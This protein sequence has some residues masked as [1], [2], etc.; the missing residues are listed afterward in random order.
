LY[1]V[2][3]Y[4]LNGTV[5]NASL[6]YKA[7]NTSDRTQGPGTGFAPPDQP[8]CFFCLNMA[9]KLPFR[10]PILRHA[11]TGLPNDAIKTIPELIDFHARAN[12]DH[13]FCMQS[14]SSDDRGEENFHHVTYSGL[15]KAILA[16]ETS[17]LSTIGPTEFPKRD[18]QGNIV[19]RAPIALL[20]ESDLSIL[21][22]LFSMFG[23]G[24]P[25]CSNG[26]MRKARYF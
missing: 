21:L 6:C 26:T 24:I 1:R 7:M 22:Y 16:C 23:L 12:P 3:F 4:V 9:S 18:E 25:V 14:D 15:E 2:P 19:K 20:M 13:V 10:R 11:Q 5:K 17:I 8:S